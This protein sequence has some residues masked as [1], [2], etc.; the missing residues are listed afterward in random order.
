MSATKIQQGM[1]SF[2]IVATP[3]RLAMY[4]GPVIDEKK[5]TFHGRLL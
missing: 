2:A 4:D 5:A 1:K 3:S